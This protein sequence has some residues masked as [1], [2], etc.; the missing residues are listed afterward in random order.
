MKDGEILIEVSYEIDE[1]AAVFALSEILD[2][3]YN[4]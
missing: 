4:D 1:R 3:Y 2:D